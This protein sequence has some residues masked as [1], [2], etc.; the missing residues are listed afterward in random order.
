MFARTAALLAAALV[1]V[2]C[3]SSPQAEDDSMCMKRKP[4]TIVS[5]NEYC[6]MVLAD[7]VDP[8]VVVD[9]KGQKVGFCCAGC[10]PKWDKLNEE[11]K[12]AAVAAAVAK[13]P[14]KD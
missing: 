8:S 9:W 10:L 3:Q 4:G 7:P 6:V 11:Q 14:I 12:D 1:L 13:G 5:V 2:A